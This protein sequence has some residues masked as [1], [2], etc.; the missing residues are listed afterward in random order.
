M[1]ISNELLSS[2]LF[3][4]RDGEVDELFQRVPFLDFA[5][6]LGGIEYEDGGIKIQRPLAVSNHSTITQLATGDLAGAGKAAQKGR[7]V[8][9]FGGDG[10]GA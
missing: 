5:K 7:D 10:H 6:K 2:T 8:L 3:S 1:A 9:L 4:I